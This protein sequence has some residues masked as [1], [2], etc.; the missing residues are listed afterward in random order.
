MLQIIVNSKQERQK[1]FLRLWK[2]VLQQVGQLKRQAAS[3]GPVVVFAEDLVNLFRNQLEERN[4]FELA[5]KMANLAII[6]RIL[7]ST[8]F[9]A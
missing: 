9:A 7:W 8:L 2:R 1:L 4:D 3:L 5:E 6:T